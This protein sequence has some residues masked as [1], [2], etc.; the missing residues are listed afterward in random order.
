MIDRQKEVKLLTKWLKDS[1][2]LTTEEL[3]EKTIGECYYKFTTPNDLSFDI[4]TIDSKAV[5]VVSILSD[6]KNHQVKEITSIE[7]FTDPKEGESHRIIIRL[8]KEIELLNERCGTIKIADYTFEKDGYP[9]AN[10][11]FENV[12]VYL[13]LS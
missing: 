6:P 5:V 1:E 8:N 3:R 4:T 12:G 13:G 10:K 7:Q 11:V 9:T 2:T